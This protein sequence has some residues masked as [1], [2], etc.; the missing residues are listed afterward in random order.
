[1]QLMNMQNQGEETMEEAAAPLEEM[2]LTLILK[3]FMRK[4]YQ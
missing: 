2:G 3:T 1:M 4:H